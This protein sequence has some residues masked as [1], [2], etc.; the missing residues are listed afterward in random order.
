MTGLPALV[1]DLARQT[2]HDPRAGVR[3]LLALD[4]PMEAR[5]IGLLL[6]TVLAVLVTR[7]SLLLMPPAGDP[8]FLALVADPFVG[9][10]AQ[11]LSLLIAAVAIAAIGQRFGGRG[12]FADALLVVAWLEFLMT[13]AQTAELFVMLL[14]P[15]IG[16]ILALAVLA[17][18]LWVL[19]NAVA[20]LHGFRNLFLVFVG[21]VLG[22]VAVVFVLATLLALL[23]LMPAV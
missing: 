11:A 6:V 23:G 2:M 1:A 19:V 4:P 7:L 22:F 15:P 13:L 10:P 5:W 9:I 17:W 12:G 8:G 20:E 18:F 16:A 21:L 14:V 3:R